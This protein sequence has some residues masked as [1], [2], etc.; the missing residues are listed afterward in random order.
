M[1]T[2]T[3][4]R[5][6][7]RHNTER[8]YSVAILLHSN[9]YQIVRINDEGVYITFDWATTEAKAREIANALWLRDMGRETMIVCS[10]R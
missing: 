9:G 7:A 10:G 6:L 8:G 3:A 1:M 4:P 5:V 2:T